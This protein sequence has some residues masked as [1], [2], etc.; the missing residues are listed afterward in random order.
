[1]EV[2]GHLPGPH[3]RVVLTGRLRLIRS[4]QAVADIGDEPDLDKMPVRVPGVLRSRRQV[5]DLDHRRG[6]QSVDGR[7]TLTA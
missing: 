6:Q 2:V 7:P 4:G 5:T 3:Q 1:L